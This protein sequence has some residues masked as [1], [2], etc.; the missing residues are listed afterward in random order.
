M[1]R[2]PIH[3]HADARAATRMVEENDLLPFTW[4]E[5]AVFA[6]L[7][8]NRGKSIRLARS[9]DSKSISFAFDRSSIGVVDRREKEG[10]NTENQC[11]QGQAG[12]VGD[13]AHAPAASP[14]LH[15]LVECTASNKQPD[16]NRNGRE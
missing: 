11:E 1:R 12:G 5:L 7:E 16:K 10:V 8:R 2:L 6:Q 14:A 15:C 3:G 4:I 13:S 9:V